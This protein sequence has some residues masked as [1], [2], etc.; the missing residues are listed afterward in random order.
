MKLVRTPR[1]LAGLLTGPLLLLVAPAAIT[2]PA[3]APAPASASFSAAATTAAASYGDSAFAATNR[4]RA[5][6]DRAVLRR[7]DCL[8]A[9]AVRQARKMA[10]R[11][12]I[13]HQDLGRVLE[14]C[15]MNRVGENVAYG[16]PTG[17]SVVNDGWMKS[18]GHRENILSRKFRLMAVAARKGDDGRWYVAQVFGRRA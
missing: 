6:R 1:Q 7:N 13:W 17:R 11:E 15:D 2:A 16:Y 9:H 8:H 10:N 12:R 3:P 4:Q 5:K 18:A 14:N